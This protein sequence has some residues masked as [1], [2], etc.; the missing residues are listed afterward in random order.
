M[1]VTIPPETIARVNEL[2]ERLHHHNYRYYALDDPEI[3]DAEY[4]RMMQALIALESEY[5]QLKD[6][7]SPTSRVGSAPL[8]GFETITHTLPMLSIDNAF[9]DNDVMEFHK[10]V[11]KNLKQA[12]TTIRYTVEPKMDGIA[13]ELVYEKGILKTASTRGDGINGERITENVKTIRTVPLALRADAPKIIPG[14]LEVRGEVIMGHKGFET[15]NQERMKEGLPPFANP[16]N[17][18]GGAL[19]QL[20]SRETAK[21]PLEIY[22]YGAGKVDGITFDTQGELLSSLETFGLRVNPLVRSDLT[23]EAALEWY[24]ELVEKRHTLPYDIDGMVIKVDRI[25]FQTDLGRTSKSPKWAIAYKFEAV[26]EST[27]VVDIEVQVGRTGTLTPVAHLEPVNVGG[28]TVSRASLHN[29]DE[30]EKLDVRIGDHVFVKR[31]GDVIPKVVRV[32]ASRRTGDE[33]PFVMP[34]HC[35]ACGEKTV[36]QHNASAVKCVNM[37]CPAQLKEGIKHFV[38]KGAFDID[39]LGD[40]LID[41]MV[42][43]G[44]VSSVADIFHIDRDLLENLERMGRKSADNLMHAIEKSKSI[45]FSRFVYSLGI[46]FVGEHV[47]KLLASSFDTLENLARGEEDMIKSIDGVGPVVAESVTLFFSKQSNLDMIDRILKGGVQIFYAQEKPK[48][49]LSG[50]S[51][52]LTGTLDTLSRNAAKTMIE[53]K[54]GKVTGSVSKK[55]D[56]IVA[57]DAPG[58]KLE[59]GK[60]LGIPIIDETTLKQLLQ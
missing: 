51:F 55:T 32:I 16:R 10:R 26:Q 38:S 56:Y 35:P 4:D 6:D 13:V 54:G 41:Q 18:A 43:K 48:G 60:K 33:V 20:D 9:N 53:E 37:N 58:S 1:T 19:R 40:K 52:V 29:E 22:I 11:L 14:Y 39:G 46:H 45:S 23:I 47:A 12:E 42:E 49:G 59:K 30:I 27:Q 50:K 3:S 31:A 7:S 44:V 17:A 28:V 15:L 36:R 24:R 21:R 5:P 25:D 34:E 57:G 8:T 2:R